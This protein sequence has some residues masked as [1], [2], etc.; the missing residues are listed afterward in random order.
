MQEHFQ[1]RFYFFRQPEI[2][3]IAEKYDLS[4]GAGKRSF[5]G[6]EDTLILNVPYHPKT[7]IL[8]SEYFVAGAVLGT[9]IDENDFIVGRQLSKDRAQLR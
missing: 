3:L 6:T 9:V 4:R 5:K 7:R 2:I 8:Q 1:D